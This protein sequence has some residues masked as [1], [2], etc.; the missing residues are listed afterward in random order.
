MY[1]RLYRES[2][3]PGFSNAEVIILSYAQG[4]V[5]DSIDPEG[6]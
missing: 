2:E 6:S 1:T 5:D 3:R 4:R